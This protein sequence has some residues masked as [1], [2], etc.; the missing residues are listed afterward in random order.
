[1]T[2][3]EKKFD[4]TISRE[5]KEMVFKLKDGREFRVISG[6]GAEALAAF[7]EW[8]RRNEPGLVQ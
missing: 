3:E 1:M 7:E 2:P 5:G 6:S 8:K 4:C